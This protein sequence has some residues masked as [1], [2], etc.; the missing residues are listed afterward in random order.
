MLNFQMIQRGK[1]GDEGGSNFREGERNPDPNP[2]PL[3]PS[4]GPIP[5]PHFPEGARIKMMN[6]MMILILKNV[7]HFLQLILLM[8]SVKQKI[9]E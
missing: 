3:P 8:E 5:N 6:L 1:D 4:P 2:D 9:I 7:N